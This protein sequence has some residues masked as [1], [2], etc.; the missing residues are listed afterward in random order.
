VGALGGIDKQG[1]TG[2]KRVHETLPP[3]LICR[4]NLFQQFVCKKS[5]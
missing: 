2:T 5:V 3:A 1:S 4:R